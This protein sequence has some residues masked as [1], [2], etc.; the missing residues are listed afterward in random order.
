[1]IFKNVQML[2][3]VSM[4]ALLGTTSA[5]AAQKSY[6]VTGNV[7]SV[8]DSSIVVDKGKEMFEMSRTADTKT[9][10]DVKVG[11]KV[12][13]KYTMQAV[14]IETKGD[15]KSAVK[16]EPKAGGKKKK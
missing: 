14:A 5:G 7:V 11:D 8:S 9:S 1:M 10:G 4:L 3:L 12:M 16:S 2:G 6:Q 15:S 13:V